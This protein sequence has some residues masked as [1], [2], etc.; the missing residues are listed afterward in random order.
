MLYFERWKIWSIVAVC[1]FGL[2]SA[3]PNFYPEGV[4]KGWPNYLSLVPHNKIN[5]GLDLRGGSYLLLEA[6]ID[7]LK[8][9]WLD[10]IVNDT[11]KTLREAHI[12]Y[13][14]LGK[15]ADAVRFRVT[16]PE[17]SAAAVTAVDKLRH[18]VGSVLLGGS[19][20]LDLTVATEDSGNI[21]TITPTPEALNDRITNGM[22]TA[23]EIVRRRIDALGTTEPS[24]QRQ[25]AGRLIVQV[26][27]FDDPQKLMAVIGKTA[28]LSF[29]AV[30]QS[31][32]P[33][34][35]KTKGV[36]AGDRIYPADEDSL[37]RN[38]GL[39]KEYLLQAV[40]VVDGAD[41]TNASSEFG[42]QSGQPE[43]AFQFNT[44]GALKFGKYTQ[45]N[46][47]H[48]FAIVLDDKVVSAPNIQ[49]AILQ[50]SGV[51]TGSFTVD[52]TTQLAIQ[53]R[54]G[55]LPTDLKV[56]EQRTVGPGLGADSIRAG[57]IAALVGA[58]AVACF[59]IFAYGL[60]GV[61]SVFALMINIVML[62]GAMSLLGQTLTLPG[63]AGIVLTMG[64]AVDSNVL[65]YERIREEL[66]A[67]RTA[68]AAIENGFARALWTVFDSHVTTVVAGLIMFALG[69]GPI[70]GFAV[71]LTIGIMISL[72]TAWTTTR[73]MIA[74]WLRRQRNITRN[75]VVPV[76]HDFFPH[77]LKIPFSKWA[78]IA[79]IGSI[80]LNVTSIGLAMTRGIN[81][82]IDFKG[83]TLIEV[84]NKAGA[85]NIGDLRSKIGAL[86]LGSPQIVSLDDGSNVLIRLEEQQGG[87]KAQEAAVEKLKASLGDTVEYRRVETVGPTVSGEITTTALEAVGAAVLAISAYI[88]FRFEWQFAIGA[89]LALIHDVLM[90][91][92]VFSLTQ[93]EFD[94]NCIAA[95]L[96]VVGYSINE[97]V[98]VSDRIRENLRK[99][100]KMP[101]PE[102]IDMSIN[103]TLSRTVLTA[104][105]VILALLALL[106]FGGSVIRSFVLAM[107][108]GVLTGTYSSMFIGS[109]VLKWLG[110]K[111][112]W[113]GAKA[114]TPIPGT[115]A[116][117]A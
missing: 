18:T 6:N 105:T 8:Q 110:V 96:T 40:P 62:F 28:V 108:F 56:I 64:M 10:S 78:A 27:G 11:R 84:H 53:L 32:S 103:T 99:F 68:I 9:N 77:N 95:L 69:A 94:N 79:V 23:Q 15:S 38:P 72:F 80:V 47:G 58:A 50:G 36:P 37:K 3:L 98:V 74:L 67:G 52:E 48:P 41:L 43:V 71:S 16:K 7:K 65:I 60:F 46:I 101:L 21:I 29:H 42:Q 104:G 89:S 26:P 34:E 93:L 44:N 54:S 35:A 116:K 49:S 114:A 106:I 57:T 51:I 31:M 22:S 66:R 55:A 90:T 17:D 97:T 91:I 20:A 19:G 14:G 13:T 113:S 75:I 82:S 76:G 100:K 73:L 59:M 5:L 107:L 61:F 12:G 88:W 2:I 70:R 45:E 30:D 87:D 1:L 81:F 86:G 25:G 115:A 39:P 24:I 4:V 111:R 117:G 85:A 92:G 63:I 109:T 83:G 33:E 112:D 102:L